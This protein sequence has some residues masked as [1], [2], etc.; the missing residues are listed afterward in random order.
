[1]G[2]SLTLIAGAFCA[3]SVR[4]AGFALGTASLV[5]GPLAGGDSVVL[6]TGS[7]TNGWTATNNAAWLHLGAASLKGAGSTNVIFSYD[8]NPGLTRIGTLT[9]ATLPLTVIQAGSTYVPVSL[10]ATTLVGS[11]LHAPTAVAVSLRGNVYVADNDNNAIKKW[12]ATNNTVTTTVRGLSS[13]TAVAVDGASNLYIAN[14]GGNSITKWTAS[15][16]NITVLASAYEPFGVT[17][18]AATNVYFADTL[19]NAIAEWTVVSNSPVVITLVS[20]GVFHPFGVAVDAAANIYIADYGGNA[21]VKWT[22]MGAKS[23]IF[24]TLVTNVTSP[25]G[26]AVDGSGN[27]YIADSGDNAIKEWTAA[28]GTVTTLVSSGL[29][30]PCGVAADGTGNVYIAD[31][32]N[33][34]VKELPR[35]FV[36]PTAKLESTAAGGDTLPAVLPATEILSTPFAPTSDQPWLTVT[37]VTNGVVSFAFSSSSTNRTG[38]ITLLGHAIPVIQSGGVT[39]PTLVGAMMAGNGLF[40]FAFTNNQGASFTVLSTTNLSLPLADWTEIG[41]PTN[42]SPGVFQFTVPVSTTGGG[43]FY[44]VRSP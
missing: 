41:V 15:N 5:E 10:P 23:G 8:A 1:V 11:G 16:S 4:A 36:D 13:P 2:L 7:P 43:R 6:A 14:S 3:V 18:D 12:T 30:Y 19:G 34:A 25:A 32:F 31:T 42:V 24:T 35:A 22:G 38:H 27:V 28:S 29:S 17:V 20:N 21:I 39:G 37:G 9:I 33:N 40:Q 44:R 26:V